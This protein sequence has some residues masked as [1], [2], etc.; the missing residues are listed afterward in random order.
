ML[1]KLATTII[2]VLT[3]SLALVASASA[4]FRPEPPGPGAASLA[5]RI[6]SGA[7]VAGFTSLGSPTVFIGTRYAGDPGAYRA[8]PALFGG[9]GSYATQPGAGSNVKVPG[10]QP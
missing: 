6:A 8:Q 5:V 2:L 9:G 7:K 10:L 3:A 1:R 4:M